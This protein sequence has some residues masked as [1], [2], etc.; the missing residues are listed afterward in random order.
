MPTTIRPFWRRLVEGFRGPAGR[1]TVAALSVAKCKAKSFGDV[2]CEQLPAAY[3]SSFGGCERAEKS[4]GAAALPFASTASSQPASFQRTQ[5]SRAQKQALFREAKA[6]EEEQRTACKER[7]R[8]QIDSV[9]SQLR[10]G[11]S[12]SQ[13]NRLRDRRRDLEEEMR[14]C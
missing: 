1:R 5:E 6:R 4:G 14:E 10:A 12:A 2:G 9:N 3:T 13:G 8:D 11:Y 7:I